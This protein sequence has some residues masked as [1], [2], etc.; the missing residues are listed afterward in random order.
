MPDAV[1]K[2]QD[3]RSGSSG[4][5][6]HGHR[7]QQGRPSGAVSDIILGVNERQIA[8]GETARLISRRLI[9]DIQV[10]A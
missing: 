8:P 10:C 7:R 1:L 6:R 9:S 3:D 4:S 5:F 2:R